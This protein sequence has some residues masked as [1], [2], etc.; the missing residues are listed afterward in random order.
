MSYYIFDTE[1]TGAK[2][3]EPIQ[4]AIVP[5]NLPEV[6]HFNRTVKPSETILPVCT[7]VH[8]VTDD[9]AATFEDPKTVARQLVQYLN[10]LYRTASRPCYAVAHNISFDVNVIDA[11]L[12]EWGPEGEEGKKEFNPKYTLCT[13][14]LAKK[15]IKKA[16]IGSYNLDTLYYYFNRDKLEYLKTTRLVHDALD[17]IVIT[18]NV[19]E[20]LLNLVPA[21]DAEDN[22]I[23]GV[24]A[25]DRAVSYILTPIKIDAWPFGKFEGKPLDHDYGYARWFMRKG[26]R[27][28]EI[29]LVYSLGLIYPEM[30]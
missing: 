27:D 21:L 23:E 4:I 13:M 14:Q 3:N 6:R 24:D 30:K 9:K 29:D 25:I 11:F 18:E 26:D 12:K 1:T 7:V 28:K 2:K 22:P 17:D 10:L 20:N 5:Q 16:D 15:L 19:L 8:G